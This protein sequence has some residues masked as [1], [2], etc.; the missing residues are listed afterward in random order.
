M[1]VHLASSIASID[2][3]QVLV[4][5][6]SDSADVL[7]LLSQISTYHGLNWR[8]DQLEGSDCTFGDN[9]SAITS[10]CALSYGFIISS[11]DFRVGLGRSPE[12]KILKQRAR[13]EV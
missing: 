11:P 3:D 8:P 6:T 12:A 5:M 2:V 10:L 1:G 7:P 13:S 4:D 9:A